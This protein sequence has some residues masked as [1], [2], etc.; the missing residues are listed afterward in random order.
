M[1]VDGG[2]EVL[3]VSVPPDLRLSVINL[4]KSP[5]DM[6]VV[7][8]LRKSGCSRLVAEV[9]ASSPVRERLAQP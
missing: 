2:F 5:L 9:S 4:L 1:E 7:N 6:A 8:D 3:W